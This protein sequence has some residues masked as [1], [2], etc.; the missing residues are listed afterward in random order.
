MTGAET[1]RFL[2]AIKHAFPG[3]FEVPDEPGALG[4]MI[5]IWT[6]MLSDVSVAEATSALEEILSAAKHPPSIGEI[7]EVIARRRVNAPDLGEAWE[8]VRKAIQRVG[9]TK[10]PRWSSPVIAAAVESFGWK[11][12][13]MSRV[14]DEA[15][16]RA[17]FERF[18]RARVDTAMKTENYGSLEARGSKPARE[19]VANLAKQL[20]GR[21]T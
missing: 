3:R 6:R 9:H 14:E 15:A 10:T 13:C 2:G 12:L 1:T 4:G 18:L 17:H 20:T 21:G 19:L 8:E 7:R 5:R 16:T 11:E